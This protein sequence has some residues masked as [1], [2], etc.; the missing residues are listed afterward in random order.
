[1]IECESEG[2]MNRRLWTA[3]AFLAQMILPQS[4]F[5]QSTA[6]MIERSL[7][8]S[9]SRE[10]GVEIRVWLSSN[11]RVNEFYRLVKTERGVTAER[12]AIAEVVKPSAMNTAREAKRETDTNRRL[13]AQQRC[14]GKLIENADLIWCRVT[15][16]DN[17]WSVTFDDLL[18]EELW[19]LPPQAETKCGS[20]GQEFIVLDG[21]SVHIDLIEPG[22][23]HRVEYSNPDTCC[24]TVACAIA[25][26]AR[27]VIRNIY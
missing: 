27:T 23:R 16:R 19:K 1:M 5:A 14:S 17:L 3:L 11:A 18:P 7:G 8:L 15:L 4:A 21:E 24:K 10:S 22:R 20:N 26:H 6:D 12:Y 25:D 2:M 13:L 9:A